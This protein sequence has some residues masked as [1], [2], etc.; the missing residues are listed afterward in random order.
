LAGNWARDPLWK[1]A[2]AVPSLD[3]RFAE[4]KSLTDAKTG[5]SLITFTR[6]STGTFV[7]S[8]GLLQSATTNEARFDHNPTTGESLGLLVEEA[9]TNF[10]YPS[11]FTSFGTV[12]A[13]N[14]WYEVFTELDTTVNSGIAPDGTTTA[15]L[16]AI[17][18]NATSRAVFYRTTQSTAG[19]YTYSVY[20]KPV[21]TD[22]ATRLLVAGESGTINFIR[23]D[24][25]LTSS[26]TAGA[27]QTGGTA[28]A[29][30]A[31]SIQQL[32][33]G[34]YRCTITATFTLPVNITCLIYP[35]NPA[36]QTV[37]SQTLVWGAQLETGAFPTSYIPTVAATATRAADVASITGTAF[38]SFYSQT[39]GT[40]LW[41]GRI[42][43][44]EVQVQVPFKITEGTSLRGTGFQIDTRAASLTSAFITR[45]AASGF[46]SVTNPSAT[47]LSNEFNL[48]GAYKVSE[49]ISASFNAGNTI[50]S[51]SLTS[52]FGTENQMDIGGSS[53]I[54]GTNSKFNGTIKRITYWPTRLANPTLQAITAS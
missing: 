24:F 11:Q 12:A 10:I 3:L 17:N 35:G 54:S 8:D 25:T 22:T 5:A 7:G 29:P 53:A 43:A 46:G 18:T 33:N 51:A 20:C 41:F 6:A 39:E 30:T 50:T 1:N 52:V 34:W 14:N 40:I 23:A 19:T 31:P 27:A 44:R 32:T 36:A 13:N 48:A 47:I 38:S 2:R 28:T 45:A 26:G 15:A 4:N 37:N 16:L 42:I 21:G 49:Q 9:R